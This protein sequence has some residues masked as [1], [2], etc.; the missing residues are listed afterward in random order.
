MALYLTVYC[1]HDDDRYNADIYKLLSN[2]SWYLYWKA[3][4]QIP[5][6]LFEMS[7]PIYCI[8][9]RSKEQMLSP[10]VQYKPEEFLWSAALNMIK[11]T[12]KTKTSGRTSQKNLA[13]LRKEKLW[14]ILYNSLH[15][16]K[17][18]SFSRKQLLSHFKSLWRGQYLYVKI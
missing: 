10:I 7:V 1:V 8:K 11:N 3:S 9:Q 13:S 17:K 16:K 4:L 15:D 6:N 2:R 5:T 18:I 14:S 12:Q